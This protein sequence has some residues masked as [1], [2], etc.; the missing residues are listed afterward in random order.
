M[1]LKKDDLIKLKDGRKAVVI[2]GH[3]S[4]YEH[5]CIIKLD[6]GQVKVVDKKVCQAL[7]VQAEAR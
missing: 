2:Y 3:E 6:N 5:C 4:D 1:K 7:E